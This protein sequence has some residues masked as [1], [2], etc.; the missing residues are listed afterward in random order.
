MADGHGLDLATLGGLVFESAVANF[1][2]AGVTL[3]ERQVMAPGAPEQVAWDCEQLVLTMSGIGPGA[4]PGQA[5]ASGGRDA[6]TRFG[7]VLRHVVF[8]FQLVRC[9]LKPTS[10]G[11]PPSAVVVNAAALAL[12]RDA[13][14]LTHALDQVGSDL[15]RQLPPGTQVVAGAVTPSGPEGGFVGLQGS[16]TLTAGN[17]T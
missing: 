6:G 16:V 12:W 5:G 15:L 14:L 1:A 2:A 11:G 7:L 13:G 9:E 8:T 3:P 4:A 10:R 17:L